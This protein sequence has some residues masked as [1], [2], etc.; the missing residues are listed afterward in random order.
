MR[1]PAS[2]S[3]TALSELPR[4]MSSGTIAEGKITTPRRGQ[5]GKLRRHIDVAQVLFEGEKALLL[6]F[7]FLF[8]RA[9]DLTPAKAAEP[10][11][12]W[13]SAA[14]GRRVLCGPSS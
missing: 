1:S 5:N 12:R 9:H 7:L 13:R 11:A 14:A 6:A 3:S 2:A 10:R 8:R 4:E